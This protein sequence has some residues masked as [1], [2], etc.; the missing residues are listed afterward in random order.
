MAELNTHLVCLKHYLCIALCLSFS[1]N[2]QAQDEPGPPLGLETSHT[3]GPIT[4]Y[5]SDEIA[6]EPGIAAELERYAQAFIAASEV[7][8]EVDAARYLD[9][10]EQVVGDL[11]DGV[12]DRARRDHVFSLVHQAILDEYRAAENEGTTILVLREDEAVTLEEQGIDV[13]CFAYS[14]LANTYLAYS[15]KSVRLNGDPDSNDSLTADVSAASV[16]TFIVGDNQAVSDLVDERRA[17]LS[18]ARWETIALHEVAEIELLQLMPARTPSGIRYFLDGM[19]TEIAYRTLHLLDE[20]ELTGQIDLRLVQERYNSDRD[21]ELLQWPEV[22]FCLTNPGVVSETLELDRYNA[23]FFEMHR[24]VEQRGVSAINQ[25]LVALAEMPESDIVYPSTLQQFFDDAGYNI[26]ERLGLYTH[27]MTLEQAV[28]HYG[29]LR[30]TAMQNEDVDSELF[31]LSQIYEVTLSSSDSR[32]YN[33]LSLYTRQAESYGRTQETFEGH[34]LSLRLIAN[35]IPRE[36]VDDFYWGVAFPT[37]LEAAVQNA[38]PENIRHVVSMA[39]IYGFDLLDHSVSFD[40][41]RAYAAR[42]D[43]DADTLR[44][45]TDSLSQRVEEMSPPERVLFDSLQQNAGE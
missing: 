45:M 23:A 15:S 26:D 39:D 20:Q 38:T 8:E 41:L 29:Q 33:F 31:A 19:S 4:F 3:F 44:E 2:L 1:A 32:V 14:P 22:N 17:R 27:G 42:I 37:H 5:L 18:M 43:N 35:I 25:V 11:G 12:Q 36:N 24:F 30:F 9:A 7:P 40:L 28:A 34:M 16:I 6:A 13:P 10:Y 21:I